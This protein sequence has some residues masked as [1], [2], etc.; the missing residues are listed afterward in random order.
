MNTDSDGVVIAESAFS[1][2]FLLALVAFLL[3]LFFGA[4]N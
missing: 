1:G 2:I 3:W 4:R